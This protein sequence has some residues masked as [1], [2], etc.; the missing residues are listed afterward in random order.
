MQVHAI[1]NAV[2]WL[3]K[4]NVGLEPELLTSDA[5]RELLAVYARAQKLV[6]FGVAA[7]SRKVDDP[8]QLA[9]VTGTSIGKAKETVATG[10]LMPSAPDLGDAL[11][12][13]DISLEQ[14]NEI[15]KAEESSPGAAAELVEAA[16]REPFHS[17]RDKARRIKLE[18]EQHR[19]LAERQREARHAR[20]HTDELGMVHVHLAV[21]PQVGAPIVARAE[22]EAANLHRQAKKEG[23][24]EPFERHL[25]DAYAALLQGGGGGRSKRPELVVL[26]SHSVVKR[27]WT[28]VEE[29]EICKIPGIGP[30]APEVAREIAADA[31]LNGVFFDGKDL[32][33]F[34]RWTRNIPVEVMIALELGPPPDFDGVKCADCGNRFRP[35]NDHIDPHV[36]GGPSSTWNIDPRCHRCHREKTERDRRSGKL[37]PP[38]P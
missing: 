31:F 36:R 30:V 15:A 12:R 4:S 18:A 6:A 33:H 29:G 2:A 35:E 5:A 13:G 14:A 21:E 1:H 20:S 37:K 25:A 24:I 17:L 11:A 23:K 16:Q 19:G 32:R 26:V 38:E 34:A 3:E 7:L 22:A 9:R 10:K 28:H 8:A 27:G